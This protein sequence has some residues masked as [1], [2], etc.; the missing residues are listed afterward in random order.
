LKLD[1]TLW[2]AFEKLVSYSNSNLPTGKNNITEY[3]SKFFPRGDDEP[4]VEIKENMKNSGE[5]KDQIYSPIQEKEDD[6]QDIYTPTGNNSNYITP[7]AVGKNARRYNTILNNAP[8]QIAHESRLSGVSP[9]SIY[10]DKNDKKY[11]GSSTGEQVKP[12]K[13][14][15]SP[16]R[17]NISLS[18]SSLSSKHH[19]SRDA[20]KNDCGDL[21]SLLSYIG[22]AYLRQMLYD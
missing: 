3:I 12:F 14:T 19:F 9:G 10:Q 18:K 16:N 5:N 17:G 13:T 4:S 21:M 11:I 22:E 20:S 1:P 6:P 7:T 15:T 8:H 2:C